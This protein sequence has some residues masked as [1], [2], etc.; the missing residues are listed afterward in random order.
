MVTFTISR[1]LRV[2]GLIQVSVGIVSIVLVPTVLL[3]SAGPV[4]ILF[5]VAGG[6]VLETG[7]RTLRSKVLVDGGGMRIRTP[8]R[9]LDLEWETVGGFLVERFWTRAG[10]LYAVVVIR[11]RGRPI[12]PYALTAEQHESADSV[13]LL[14][15]TKRADAAGN[16]PASNTRGL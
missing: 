8:I 6:F 13:L 11:K 12:R 2:I 3:R 14:L 4:T 1:T 9:W 5:A 7:L 16:I 10:P 15:E